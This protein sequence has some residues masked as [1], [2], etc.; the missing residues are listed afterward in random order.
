MQINIY[1]KEVITMCL[2]LSN[3]L[4]LGYNFD[5]PRLMLVMCY[6]QLHSV[7]LHVHWIFHPQHETNPHVSE[8]HLE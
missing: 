8:K 6:F 5:F 1:N 4:V 2:K 7:I 3:S